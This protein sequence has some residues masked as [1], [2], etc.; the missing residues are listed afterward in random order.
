MG[1]STPRAQGSLSPRTGGTYATL[2]VYTGATCALTQL[3]E[4]FGLG[5]RWA[6]LCTA[7]HSSATYDLS[8]GSALYLLDAERLFFSATLPSP[9]SL[10]TSMPVMKE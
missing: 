7:H 2:V 3:L 5:R 9:R 4:V 6:R 1:R 8:H 10:L